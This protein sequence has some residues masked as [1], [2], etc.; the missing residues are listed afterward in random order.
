VHGLILAGGEGSRLA[1]EGVAAPKPLLLLQGQPLIV[2]LLETLAGLGCETVT[3]LVRADFEG[4]FQLLRGSDFGVPLD[5]RSCRTPSSLHT[6]VA[7]L[8]AVPPGAVFCS[9]VDT[10]MPFADWRRVY[11]ATDEALAAGADAVLAVTP[12][13]DDE[14]PLYVNRDTGGRVLGLSDQL[15]VPPCVTGGAYG[16]GPPT[17]LAARDALD[18]GIVRMRGFLKWFIEQGARL[19]TVSV[20]RI[21][22]I[23]HEADLRLADAWL[24]SAEAQAETPGSE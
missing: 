4:V 7:G 24:G 18:R 2:R 15:V 12:F 9:M 19:A 5:V 14:S 23:D 3:C 20:P 11:R 13:V 17:R 1:A 22:D 6:L 10:V 16:F 21:I 8:D